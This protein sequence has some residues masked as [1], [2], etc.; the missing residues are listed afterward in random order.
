MFEN[1]IHNIPPVVYQKKESIVT[2]LSLIYAE[3]FVYKRSTSIVFTWTSPH[4][5][6][7]VTL[8]CTYQ[9]YWVHVSPNEITLCESKTRRDNGNFHDSPKSYKKY[10]RLGIAESIKSVF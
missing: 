4:K 7:L 2:A 10:H 5:H 6:E 1:E 8:Q 3:N 9:A